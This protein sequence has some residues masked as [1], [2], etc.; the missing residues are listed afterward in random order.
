MIDSEPQAFNEAMST[1]E[2]P[3]WKEA[4]NSEIESVLSSLMYI[5]NCTRP[6][7]AYSVNKLSRYTSNPGH[8]HWKALLRVLGYLNKTKKNA[9]RYGKYPAVLEGYS[10][11][12][13]ISDSEESKSTSGYVFTLGGAAIS[14]KSSKQTCIARS[15]MESEFI[16]LD[17]AGEEAEWL[18]HF[19]EDIPIWPKPVPA[20]CIH[21]VA[22]TIK[23]TWA[24]A[25]DRGMT[26]VSINAGLLMTP[27]LSIRNPYLK[28][29]AEMYE[30]GV[31]AT[32]D[33]GFLADAHVCVFED[34]SSYGRYICFNN[35]VNRPEDAAKLAK[36]LTPSLP[37]LPQSYIEDMR[38]I[39]QR[40][41][42][43][44]L[45]K[46]MAEYESKTSVGL[47]RTEKS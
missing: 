10:D 12:N 31:F 45:N 21:F 18:R 8:E 39:P 26:M 43:K 5:M 27:D 37:S 47:N 42:S 11:A 24:L 7:I 34:V 46:L 29:A 35:V 25:M 41:S 32:V 40:I 14:W 19:L 1:P 17:K 3:F 36:I 6:D 15:T 16:A 44:K 23:D 9:L 28:G 4:V 30:D 22:W 13:W 20:I 2:A 38:I 33:V